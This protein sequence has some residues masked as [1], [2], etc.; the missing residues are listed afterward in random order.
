MEN[1]QIVILCLSYRKHTREFYI[2]HYKLFTCLLYRV[3]SKE[4]EDETS[5]FLWSGLGANL[6]K[7]CAEQSG[8]FQLM[9]QLHFATR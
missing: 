3:F 2:R 5:Y 9:L 4:T 1:L 7:A 6:W 8:D